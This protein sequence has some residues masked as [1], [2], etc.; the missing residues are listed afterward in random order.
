MDEIEKETRETCLA[1]VKKHFPKNPQVAEAYL[2]TPLS[3]FGQRSAD[4]YVKWAQETKTSSEW[5]W[6]EV[7]GMLRR[8]LE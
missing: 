7:M 2:T 8:M 4:D 1:F 3:V 6:N 5:A